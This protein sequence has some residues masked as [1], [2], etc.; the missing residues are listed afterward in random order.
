MP[1]RVDVLVWDEVPE[2]FRKNISEK[3][4]VLVGKPAD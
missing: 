4:A 2:K 1:F 3:Y